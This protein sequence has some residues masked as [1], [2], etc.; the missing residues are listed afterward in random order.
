VYSDSVKCKLP[1]GRDSGT[2]PTPPPGRGGGAP[3]ASPGC[4]R[5]R[6]P[7]AAP[8]AS[9]HHE[10]SHDVHV[11]NGRCATG[12]PRLSP[13]PMPTCSSCG[14]G[15]QKVVFAGNSTPN[16]SRVRLPRGS[17]RGSIRNRKSPAEA[18]ECLPGIV[19]PSALNPSAGMICAV[20][21]GVDRDSPGSAAAGRSR[22]WR[23]TR[24]AAALGHGPA[25][26]PAML[27]RPLT[28]IGTPAQ[29]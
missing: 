15:Q 25:A 10:R 21:H 12:S 16:M 11:R 17:I 4:R 1:G 28:L 19:V 22:A 8:A 13:T 2:P 20:E 23:S 27:P 7:P 24:P 3:P 29:S 5:C 18:A 9:H 26:R 6:C 14:A